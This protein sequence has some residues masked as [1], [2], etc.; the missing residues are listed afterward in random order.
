MHLEIVKHKDIVNDNN[1]YNSKQLSK[2]L[3]YLEY[4]DVIQ[5]V[6]EELLLSK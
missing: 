1:F 3:V 4:Y 2:T 5:K 6:L